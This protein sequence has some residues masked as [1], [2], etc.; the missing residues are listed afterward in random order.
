MM[1]GKE[2]LHDH[3]RNEQIIR[4]G[5]ARF[6]F[7][8]SLVIGILNVLL[9]RFVHALGRRPEPAQQRVDGEGHDG[10]H[11][12]LAERVEAAEVDQ[13]DVDDVCAAAFR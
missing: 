2:P 12:D 1:T 13:D 11:G 9:L 7:R 6:T 4:D 5:I 3:G 8:T 10:E